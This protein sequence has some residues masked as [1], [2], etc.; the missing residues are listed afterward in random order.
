MK[1][2]TV[3]ILLL[4]LFAVSACNLPSRQTKTP[5]PSPTPAEGWQYYSGK[6]IQ[7]RLPDSYVEED[8]KDELPA[9]ISTLANIVHQSD[10]QVETYLNNLEGSVEWWGYDSAAPAISPT[11]LLILRNQDLAGL[12]L[13]L[14]S[15][16]LMLLVGGDANAV[17][18]ETLKLDGRDVVRLSYSDQDSAWA[19]YAFNEEG[20]LWLSLFLTTPAILAVEQA[21]FEYSVG[22][23]VIDENAL[24]PQP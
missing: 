8:F 16:T 2:K 23:I 17:R 21:D 9:I 19:A 15:N 1:K 3:L 14:L 18:S 4:I 13:N 20:F 7:I 22:T 10:G 5:Q 11:R 6:A 12:P 24:T